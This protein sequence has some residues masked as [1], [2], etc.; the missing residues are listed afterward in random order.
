MKAP[1]QRLPTLSNNYIQPTT[2]LLPVDTIGQEASDC[3]S[4]IGGKRREVEGRRSMIEVQPR[5]SFENFE[6]DPIRDVVTMRQHDKKS[7]SS[8]ECGFREKFAGLCDVS[9][10][11]RDQK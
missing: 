8:K 1:N 5:S 4:A 7:L 9:Q 11:Y 2:S 6:S 3:A 10:L